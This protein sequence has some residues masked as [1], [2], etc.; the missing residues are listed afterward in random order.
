V[1]E[2]TDYSHAS[3]SSASV[4]FACNTQSCQTVPQL[5]ITSQLKGQAPISVFY[6]RYSQPLLSR[7]QGMTPGQAIEQRSEYDYLGRP[8]RRSQPYF[9][10]DPLYWISSEYDKLNRQTLSVLPYNGPAGVAK[11][12][13]DY[14]VDNLGRRQ[15]TV[16]D[17]VNNATTV[18]ANA[19]GQVAEVRD[20]DNQSLRYDY[21]AA[22]RLVQ[23]QDALSNRITISYDLLGRRTS[24]NDPD[25]GV[26]HYTYDAFSQLRSQTD[27]KQQTLSMRYDAL[28]RLK[29]RDV[30]NPLGGVDT[31]VWSYDEAANG[32]GSLSSVKQAS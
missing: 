19:L 18:F 15:R 31:S 26:S 10:G 27:A 24:L 3:N 11:V 21:D 14:S 9:V 23:T 17:T 8:K 4:N 22:G 7:T 16:T 5:Q 12:S 29:E 6:N 13:Y 25:L 20:A 30:P 28:G 1:F 32:I 2:T